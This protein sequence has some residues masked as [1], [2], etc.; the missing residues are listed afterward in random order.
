MFK[1]IEILRANRKAILSLIEN[2]TMEELNTIPHGFNNN[3][4][5]NIAHL[6]VTQQLL[7]YRLSG[8]PL[9]VDEELVNE[10]KKGTAPVKEIN[11]Q[12]FEKIKLLF[13]KLPEQLEADLNHADFTNFTTYPTSAGVTLNSIEDALLFNNYHEGLHRGAIIALKNVI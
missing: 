13:M 7:C 12:R 1:T 2:L 4:A 5:W 6:V 11:Q 8:L 9:H 10:F 3:I